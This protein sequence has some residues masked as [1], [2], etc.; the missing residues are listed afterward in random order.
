MRPQAHN[1]ELAG[2]RIKAPETGLGRF[3]PYLGSREAFRRVVQ[4]VNGPLMGIW[5]GVRSAV[6]SV[7]GK[8]AGYG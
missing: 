5:Q 6:V 1:N 2:G 8:R 4:S 3:D 7:S